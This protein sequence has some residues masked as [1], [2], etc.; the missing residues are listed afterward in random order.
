MN[1]FK[2]FSSEE[3]HDDL[4]VLKLRGIPHGT[5]H[6]GFTITEEFTTAGRALLVDG[7]SAG[8]SYL[9]NACI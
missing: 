8:K 2:K 9:P 1:G 6:F 4:I 5:T 3:S 7:V